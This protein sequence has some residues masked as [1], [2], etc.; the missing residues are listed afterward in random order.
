M[1][2]ELPRILDWYRAD[3]WPRMRRVL[4][5]GP[6]VLA[7]GGLVTGA[8]FLGRVPVGL[9]GD[10][11]LVGVVLVAGGALFTIVGMSRILREDDSLALR[12]DGVALRAAGVDTLVPWD[13]LATVSWNAAR[14]ELLLERRDGV[15][16]TVGWRFA[17]IAGGALAE[18]ILS[19]RRKAAMSLLR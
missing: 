14:G 10:A 11:T 6:L 17:G 8:S 18:R 4:F 16:L 13:D 9:R 7:V 1:S 3:P 19:T 5:T 12:T 15:T 2:R